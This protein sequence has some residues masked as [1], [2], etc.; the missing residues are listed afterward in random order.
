M[1]GRCDCFIKDGFQESNHIPE[2]VGGQ[3]GHNSVD[4]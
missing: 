1:L 2:A 3:F 4:N